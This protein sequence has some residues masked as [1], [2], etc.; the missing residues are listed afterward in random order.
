[1]G[2][3]TISGVA[4]VVLGLA[5]VIFVVSSAVGFC[6]TYAPFGISTRRPRSLLWSRLTLKK[7]AYSFRIPS[8]LNSCSLV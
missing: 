3:V 4:A 2:A 5:A 6:P 7:G 8:P 1:M